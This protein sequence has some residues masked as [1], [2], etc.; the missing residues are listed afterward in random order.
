MQQITR[1][2]RRGVHFIDNMEKIRWDLK[3]TTH[4]YPDANSALNFPQYQPPV[5]KI[6]T[7]VSTFFEIKKP[8]F[9]ED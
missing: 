7:R 9:Q 3:P 1:R 2:V 8:D 4:F 6:Y 5:K